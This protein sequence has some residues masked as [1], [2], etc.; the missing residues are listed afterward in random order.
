[1]TNVLRKKRKKAA[2]LVTNL[3]IS[4]DPPICN[5]LTDIQ[6]CMYKK[7]TKMLK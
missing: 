5:L 3:F 7:T 1:M 6:V 4:S 2:F